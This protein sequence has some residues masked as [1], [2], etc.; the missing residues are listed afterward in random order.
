M[1]ENGQIEGRNAVL[2]LLESGKDINK[3]LVQAGEKHGSIMKIIA[4]AK[5]NR[6]SNNRNAKKQTRRNN[7][8]KEP[9]RR[10][11]NSPTIRIFRSR[12]HI[13]TCKTKK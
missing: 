13:R 12:R 7:T 4:K 6:N 8:N 10:N 2:E 1:E 9:P 3:I 5:A 11:S